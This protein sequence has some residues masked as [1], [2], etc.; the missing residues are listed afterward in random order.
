MDDLTFDDMNI[1][2]D[3]EELQS[4]NIYLSNP[5]KGLDLCSRIVSLGETQHSEFLNDIEKQI[6]QFVEITEND[7]NTTGAKAYAELLV[8]KEE[9]LNII[10]FPNL[11]NHFTIA[12]GGS[13]SSGKSRFLNTVL[14]LD[15]LLPTDTNPTTSIPTY[16]MKGKSTKY[17]ALN[18]FNNNIAIDAD[19]IQAISHSFQEQYNVTFS[20]IL[21]LISIEVESFKYSN[22]TFLDTPGYSKSD[23]LN[24]KDNIDENIA[25]DHLR[26]TD[27]LIWLVSCQTPI[28]AADIDFIKSLNISRPILFILSKADY[29]PEKDL[30]LQINKSKEAILKAELPTY[31]VIGF[32]AKEN[33]EYSPDKNVLTNFF[34]AI[35]TGKS[36]TKIIRRINNI[37]N[38]YI[39]YYDSRI[40]EYREIRRVLNSAVLDISLSD[41]ISSELGLVG[42]SYKKKIDELQ[43]CKR[44]V[45]QI[46]TKLVETA[47]ELLSKCG[48]SIENRSVECSIKTIKKNHSLG[49]KKIYRY[50]GSIQIKNANDLTRFRD[51]NTI[52]GTIYKV[53]SIGIFI[54]ISIDAD[55]AVMSS[56]IKKVTG[57]DSIADLFKKEDK[58]KIQILDKKRCI[59]IA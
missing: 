40:T 27:F 43:M 15:K 8:A 17:S 44:R 29:K 52:E 18:K 39:N 57:L 35:K 59:V 41:N 11:E 58:V 21:K 30:F 23:S 19:A 49:K 24:K 20:H 12:V 55:I 26:T 1:D 45:E 46:N 56:E 7:E 2:I 53:T 36:G 31:D 33:R 6:N 16:I 37:F 48:V 5:E 14:G 32:S 25:R 42:K 13:F 51:L 9:L 3:A 34:T 22:L 47:K 28:P 4:K 54:K 50:N 38:V 10:C